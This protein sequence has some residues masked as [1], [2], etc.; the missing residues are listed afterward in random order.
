MQ[1]IDK[2]FNL[3]LNPISA[4]TMWLQSEK[5][6]FCF[7]DIETTGLSPKISSLYLI[8]ALWFDA[9]DKQI[10]TRQWFADD[11]VSERDII[12][13]FRDFIAGFSTLVHYNG[14]GFDIPYIEKKCRE[15][16]LPS[17]F[18]TIKSLDIYQEIRH[19]KSLFGTSDL[20][21]FTVEKLVGFMRR[22]MLSGKDCIDVYSQFMQKKYFRD[23]S[24]EMEKQKL[25]LH[26]M[27]DIIGTFHSAELLL[28]KR[29]MN[30]KSSEVTL[31]EQE[32]LAF[33]HA[34]LPSAY[35]FPFPA[36]WELSPFG[37]QFEDKNTVLTVPFHEGVLCHFYENYKDYFY[38]PAEDT[39][40]H[41]SVGTFVE[42]E[43]REPAK[44]SNCYTK[45]EG[46]FIPVPPAFNRSG[47]P[48]FRADYKSKQNYILWDDSSRQDPS[49]FAEILNLLLAGL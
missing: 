13:A 22:D 8:G 5:E 23:S 25:L 45:K 17:P 30:L 35:P 1:I 33:L 49:L 37:I 27:E 38:L 11:Y 18:D 41:K 12:C 4:L 9:D 6:T 19:L 36:K 20:K 40:I 2:S 28:Y 26:N 48:L 32:Y 44:A 14:S 16:E 31:T 39:A 7:F 21:L 10:H 42:K 46:T 47:Y 3:P 34:T 29:S 24:M 43:F 15:L